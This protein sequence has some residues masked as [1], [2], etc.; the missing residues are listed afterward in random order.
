MK[1]LKAILQNR[2]FIGLLALTL[3]TV[4]VGGYVLLADQPSVE[5]D[6]TPVPP[7]APAIESAAPLQQIPAE[8]I[9]TEITVPSAEK[10]PEPEI[11][12]PVAEPVFIPDETPV[13]ITP[14]QA[15]V[16]P[17][18]GEVLAAFS[19]DR[20][21]YNETLADWR[22]HDGVDIAAM[23]DSAVLSASSGTVCAVTNDPL[24][25]TTVIIDH[26][27]GYQTTYAN[28]QADPD[29][30]AG[31][32]VSAG[33]VIGVVGTTAAAEAAQGPHLHFSVS[34]NKIPMDPMEYL[35]S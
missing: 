21:M 12:T 18:E 28:L 14:P 16:S 33:Q 31:D 2:A 30:V 19:V 1:N 9:P 23:A 3:L 8:N 4:G 26:A 5:P 35:H 34:K 29:V 32:K 6:T 24:M 22:T 17:L 20:L 27:D 7:P 10:V 25:G 15:I 13:I 11:D